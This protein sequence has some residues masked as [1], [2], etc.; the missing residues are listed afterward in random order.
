[1]LRLQK[2]IAVGK[3]RTIQR[4]FADILS[5]GEFRQESDPELSGSQA[6]GNSHVEDAGA[7]PRAPH[8]RLVFHF[9]R[10]SLGRLRQLVDTINY[11][12]T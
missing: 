11:G 12:A 3:L 4:D 2:P 8:T 7:L 10:R 6:L 9:N 1:V 5:D